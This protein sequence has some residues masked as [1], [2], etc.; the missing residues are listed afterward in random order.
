MR[1]HRIVASAVAALLAG[2]GSGAAPATTSGPGQSPSVEAWTHHR[3]PT[4]L[5]WR[6]RVRGEMGIDEAVAFALA[7]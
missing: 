7:A 5:G 6:S 1:G 3:S 4:G 2:C